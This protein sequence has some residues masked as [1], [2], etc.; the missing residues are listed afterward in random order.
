MGEI[1]EI[2]VGEY[3]RIA[4]NQGIN[5]IIEIEENNRYILDEDIADEYGDLT[6]FL[7]KYQLKDEIL[8]HSP[9]IIDLIEVGDYVNGYK[10]IGVTLDT[11]NKCVDIDCDKPSYES[12]L[13]EEQIYSIVTKEQ[14]KNMEYRLE[15]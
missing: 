5:R 14:F 1:G 9:N 10:V 8:K 15:N 11:V 3:V 4:R 2:K 6:C 7:E 12:Y 13:F